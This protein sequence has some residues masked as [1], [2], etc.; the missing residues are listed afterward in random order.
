MSGDARLL[1]REAWLDGHPD[2]ADRQALDAD[3][4]DPAV[5]ADL[6]LSLALRA[7][8][9]GRAARTW[10]GLEQALDAA[11][12]SRGLRAVARRQRQRS[13]RSIFALAIAATLGAAIGLTWW[14][15]T[16]PPSAGAPPR[17]TMVRGSVTCAGRVMDAG[18]I[19]PPDTSLR[20]GAG[21]EVAIRFTDDTR[22]YLLGATLTRRESD[23]LALERGYLHALVTTR[24]D[25]PPL[26]ITTPHG[27]AR[28]LGT[29]LTMRS[30]VEGSRCTVYHGSVAFTPEPGAPA[31]DLREGRWVHHATDG[32]LTRGAVPARDGRYG[33]SFDVSAAARYAEGTFLLDQDRRDQTLPLRQRTTGTGLV[34]DPDRD[35]V[36]FDPNGAMRV[37]PDHHG[38]ARARLCIDPRG[39]R[40][41]RLR[42][43]F[44]LVRDRTRTDYEVSA[45]PLFSPDPSPPGLTARRCDIDL[46]D[47]AWHE[48]TIDYLQVG[49]DDDGVPIRETLIRLDGRVHVHR[50]TRSHGAILDL[51]STG[52]PLM[53]SEVS[54]ALAPTDGA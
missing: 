6:R 5:L 37:D 52:N 30:D 28:I 54:V 26:T 50:W 25:R 41:L 14:A 18:A 17:L 29:A 51:Q 23:R 45:G 22:L 32:T 33:G 24:P 35:D 10:R 53:V 8:A 31:V 40:R 39:A 4:H 2:T 47:E 1:A 46:N 38:E 44:R 11:G 43:R 7:A 42:C 21:A 49:R 12:P 16:S 48:L 34:D 3:C 15:D 27:N 36:S 20:C 13:R 9:P 19:W